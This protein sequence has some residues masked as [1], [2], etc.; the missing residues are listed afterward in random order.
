MPA[1]PALVAPASPVEALSPR[2]RE[3]LS[4]MARGLTNLELA[5]A[6]KISPGT[7]RTHVT[8]VLSQLDVTNRTEAA[9]LYIAWEAGPARVDEVL[10]RPAIA[11]LPVLAA[12]DDPR[13]RVVSTGLTDDLSS[14]FAR[15]CWFPVIA[16]V[17]LADA[18]SLGATSS[19]IGARLGARFLV[20]A[21]LRLGDDA[22]R[23]SVRIVDTQDGRCLWTE[24]TDFPSEALFEVQTTLCQEIVAA[25]Y[26]VLIA[27]T[28]AGRPGPRAASELASWELAHEGLA[29][30]ATREPDDNKAAHL[31][32]ARALERE[33]DLVLAHFGL[34][35]A[36]Y[37]ALLNQWA[38]KNEAL[39][40]LAG[41]AERCLEFAP[42][43]AEG[44]YLLGRY[45]QSLGDW[46]GAI[47]PLEAAIGRNPSMAVAH[48]ALAQALQVAGRDGE[49]LER[50][51]HAV[52]LGPRA[53]VAGLG[54]L[55]FMQGQYVEALAAAERAVVTN[56]RYTFARALATASAWWLGDRARAEHHLRAL[57][58]Q[59]PRFQAAG[60]LS[61]FG[62]GAEAVGRLARAIDAA[63]ARP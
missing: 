9:A 21:N 59:S 14:L 55:H 8:T 19:E 27:R 5:S 25:A 28:Q 2:R 24:Q 51:R 42:H 48:A 29:L 44:Y 60:F 11:V 34:G 43:A 35:L 7:V 23:L 50:M 6:L 10:R 17:A 30:Q 52:R 16:N 40:R 18:R 63:G 36:S 22:W 58:E 62:D 61:T 57:R 13:S 1:N 47:A 33:P 31:R 32:L 12:S 37:D 56:P 15:W 38:P 41:A 45:H 46:S 54:T 3:L 49:S 20:D 53:F 26:P 39:A 4:L